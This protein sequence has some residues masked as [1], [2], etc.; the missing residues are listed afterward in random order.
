[1][2]DFEVLWW[3]RHRWS[4]IFQQSFHFAEYDGYDSL[5]K[6]WDR[7]PWTVTSDGFIANRISILSY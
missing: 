3:N 7:R 5:Q 4:P 2:P 6:Y 1:M